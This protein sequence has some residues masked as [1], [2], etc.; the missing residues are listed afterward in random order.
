MT[1]LRRHTKTPGTDGLTVR[2]GPGEMGL[3]YIHFAAHR[4][5]VGGSLGGETGQNETALVVLGGRCTVRVESAAGQET[6][7]A[8]GTRADV[9]ERVPP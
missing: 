5:P 2:A 1:L 7:S 6:F 9:W 3:E 8:V 4:L